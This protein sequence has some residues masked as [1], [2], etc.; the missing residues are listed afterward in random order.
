[1]VGVKHGMSKLTQEQASELAEFR[2]SI[3]SEVRQFAKRFAVSETA[4]RDVLSGRTWKHLG[5]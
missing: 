2:S 5:I 1:M 3:N 4:I